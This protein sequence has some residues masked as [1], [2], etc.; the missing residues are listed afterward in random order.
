[1]THKRTPPFVRRLRVSRVPG[2]ACS[3]P[4]SKPPGRSQTPPSR[5]PKR[6]L[7]PA[8]RRRRPAHRPQARPLRCRRGHLRTPEGRQPAEA[9]RVR[10]RS[11]CARPPPPPAPPANAPAGGRGRGPTHQYRFGELRPRLQRQPSVRR[12]LQR[13]QLLRHRQPRARPNSAP[14]WF[15]PA[16]RATFRSTATCSSCRPKP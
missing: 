3:L 11:E 8:L 16:A 14:R 13:H 6:L 12:Q 7:Q 1:M 15:A 10:A 9:A 2:G 5:A 4:G